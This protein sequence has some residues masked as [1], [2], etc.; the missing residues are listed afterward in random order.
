M[1]EGGRRGAHAADEKHQQTK[2]A[3]RIIF[4]CAQIGREHADEVT[5]KHELLRLPAGLRT[6]ATK[7]YTS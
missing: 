1:D 3:K 7:L 5:D 6:K 2:N 4:Q